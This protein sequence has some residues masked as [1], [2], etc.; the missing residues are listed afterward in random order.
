MTR[1]PSFAGRLIARVRAL[2]IDDRIAYAAAANARAENEKLE[3]ELK[4]RV[5]MAELRAREAEAEKAKLEAEKAKLLALEAELELVRK[6]RDIGVRSNVTRT[7]TSI[8]SRGPNQSQRTKAVKPGSVA[9]HA[10][11]AT[12]QTT[13]PLARGPAS[14]SV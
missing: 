6:L 3:A 2:F 4:R 9:S 1:M 8:L 13:E 11:L 14:G 12:L 10:H 5:Q 7:E